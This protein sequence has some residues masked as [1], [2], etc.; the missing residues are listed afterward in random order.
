[1][2]AA[3]RHVNS[4]PDRPDLLVTGG[5]QI[6]DAFGESRDRGREL[7]GLFDRIL[8]AENSLPVEHCLGN[9]DGFGFGRSDI[10][11]P[12]GKRFACEVL[13]LESPFR[14]FDR[15]GWHFVVLDSTF[16]DPDGYK[17]RL[18][19]A[20]FAWLAEDLARTPAD[21]PVII[22]SHIPI[23]SASA[24]FDGPN[25][26]SG[27]WVVPGAWMHLDARR[28]KDL[29]RNH[30]QVKL[31]ISGHIHLVDRVEYLGVAYLCNGAVCGN[32][33]RGSF[34]GC[35]PGYAVIDLYDDGSFVSEYVPW[36]VVN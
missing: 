15:G 24:Y 11:D 29:F 35:L 14:S 25:E 3:L 7:W 12:T 28:I 9:H 30:P 34:Q 27:D 1:M 16:P 5:D 2:A 22:V 4:I 33:W 20:Q 18:D 6:M 26:E 32:W 10:D 36:G 8:R 31:A 17:A 13:E 21:T 23:L 19:E